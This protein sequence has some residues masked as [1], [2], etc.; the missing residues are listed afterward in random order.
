MN[1]ANFKPIILPQ[2]LI[3][4][5]FNCAA[6]VDTSGNQTRGNDV[7]QNQ[8]IQNASANNVAPSPTPVN[9][10]EI[11]EKI[12]KI[13]GKS[14]LSNKNYEE[15]KR[16]LALKPNLN[17]R[18]AENTSLLVQQMY[19]HQKVFEMLLDAG[20]DP[21][22][23]SLHIGCDKEERCLKPPAYIAFLNHNTEALRLLLKHG[24]DPNEGSY[25][26]WAVSRDYRD[27]AQLFI[28]YKA[29]IN[30]SKDIGAP[31]QTP[32]FFASSPETGKMLLKAG[33]DINHRDEK[34]QT[35]LMNI[36]SEYYGS[37]LESAMEKE[38]LETVRFFI[39]NGAELMLKTKTAYR[40][41]S[42]LSQTE[43]KNSSESFGKPERNNQFS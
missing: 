7:L 31:G 28:E 8:S 3:S 43:I 11:I 38:P 26:A 17:V 1:R 20:A 18:D 41:C 14:N 42:R 9:Q 6:C 35:P 30:Y 23:P 4:I 10:Y 29:D 33:S 25:L 2:L 40:Y 21:N 27:I 19:K 37:E 39:K 36:I 12:K 15:L 32:L 22:F 5:V 24:I 16:L 13:I 34:G